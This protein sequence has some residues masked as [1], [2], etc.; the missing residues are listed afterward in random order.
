MPPIINSC[1]LQLLDLFFYSFPIVF[2]RWLHPMW[3]QRSR[4]TKSCKFLKL[5]SY[6]LPLPLSFNY[7]RQNCHLLAHNTLNLGR[8]NLIDWIR[9]HLSVSFDSATNSFQIKYVYPKEFH[10]LDRTA[11]TLLPDTLEKMILLMTCFWEK[12]I[13]IQGLNSIQHVEIF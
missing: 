12:F 11:K 3:I 8:L 2:Q 9:E 1:C 10:I 4:I 7:Q 6:N 13:N 5:F